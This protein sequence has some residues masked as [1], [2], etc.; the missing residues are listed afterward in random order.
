[1]QMLHGEKHS[2]GYGSQKDRHVKLGDACFKI[3]K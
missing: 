3:K 2:M 1:M